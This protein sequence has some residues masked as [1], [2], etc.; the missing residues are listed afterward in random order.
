MPKTC[1]ITDTSAQFPRHSLTGRN[2]IQS[3]PFRI[4][5]ND[6]QV[7]DDP[8]VKIN[9]FP[10]SEIRGSLPELLAPSVED[11]VAA[12]KSISQNYTDILAVVMS[13]HLSASF[14]NLETA[15]QQTR[16]FIQVQLIDSQTTGLGLGYLVQMAADMAA[17]S[18]PAADIEYRLRGQI[19]HI[20]S[21]FCLPN[22]TY[23][24][25]TDLI[26]YPQ[27]VVGEMLS[28]LP[29]FSFEEGKLVSIEKVKNYRHLLD[30]FQE[31]LD[32]FSDLDYVAVMQSVPPLLQEAR[33]LK[34]HAGL[35]FPKTPF[36][37][38]TI[39]PVIAALFGPRSVGIF[40]MEKPDAI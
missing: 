15:V 34:E 40:A 8:S 11:Y 16:G 7:E 12:I 36:S 24:H 39:N 28:I 25:G 33:S 14:Q 5:L 38:H 26:G 19:P 37:E 30:Y 32:E 29:V 3:V 22:L 21:Q 17:R 6:K 23:L 10:T 35:N 31:F 18:V 1:I 20:Y 27:A 4:K 2:Y 13:S 9:H